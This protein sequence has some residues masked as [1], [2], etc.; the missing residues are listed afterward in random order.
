M[1]LNDKITV[2]WQPH[3]ERLNKS[4]F[5]VQFKFCDLFSHT[6]TPHIG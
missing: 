2:V 5:A 4:F 6:E 1:E 3:E